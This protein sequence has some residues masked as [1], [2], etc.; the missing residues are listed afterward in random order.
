[1]ADQ[2]HQ[3]VAFALLPALPSSSLRRPSTWNRAAGLFRWDV[4]SRLPKVLA[5]SG[6]VSK[7]LTTT[8]PFHCCASVI[9]RQG[10][11]CWSQ[12]GSLRVGRS[13]TACADPSL[14]RTEFGSRQTWVGENWVR[15]RHA[16]PGLRSPASCRSQAQSPL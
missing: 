12:A 5:E 4:T 13:R 11:T 8:S 14:P 9:R 3:A 2:R 7:S 16:E 10:Q 15:S 1:M 6:Q